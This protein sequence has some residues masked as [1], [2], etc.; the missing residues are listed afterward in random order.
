MQRTS[1]RKEYKIAEDVELAIRSYLEY[2]CGLGG[3]YRMALGSIQ[4]YIESTWDS[5]HYKTHGLRTATIED[6]V[7]PSDATSPRHDSTPIISWTH[8]QGGFNR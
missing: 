7:H 1:V 2:V 3:N 5:A 6:I 8:T 4:K